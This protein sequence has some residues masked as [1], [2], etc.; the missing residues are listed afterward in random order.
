MYE[1]KT[2]SSNYVYIDKL[3]NIVNKYNITLTFINI[4]FINRYNLEQLKS[5]V[6]R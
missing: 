1:Y 3:D 4:T 5:N 6:L 2:S